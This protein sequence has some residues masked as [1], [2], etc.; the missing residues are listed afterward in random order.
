MPFST[1]SALTSACDRSFTADSDHCSLRFQCGS[2]SPRRF[3]YA[4]TTRLE[5]D[6]GVPPE[7]GLLS[8][9]LVV[10]LRL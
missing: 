4:G 1:A 5:A 6:L 8:P 10:R 7:F 9:R 2:V 3:S